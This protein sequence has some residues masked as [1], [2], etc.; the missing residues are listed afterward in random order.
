MLTF[1]VNQDISFDRN[2]FSQTSLENVEVLPKKSADSYKVIN[3]SENENSGNMVYTSFV[4]D[5]PIKS[6]F[7]EK[8]DKILQNIKNQE[9]KYFL[10]E[11]IQRPNENA[12]DSTYQIINILADKNIYP[13]KI[14][15]T[16]EEGICLRFKHKG[17]ILY[18]EIYNT[19]ELGYIIEDVSFQKIIE[20]KD[21]YSFE[22][23]TERIND[24]FKN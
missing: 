3:K 16:I 4:I 9:D 19:G 23:L 22:I 18:L 7:K 1:L 5:D 6:F 24:F 17:Q 20:N 2:I 14:D 12:L 15:P 21:E 8:F 11:N 10:E 13:E